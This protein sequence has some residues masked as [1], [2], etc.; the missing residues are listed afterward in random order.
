MIR[1]KGELKK[2][3]KHST[4]KRTWTFLIIFL[5]VFVLIGYFLSS[6]NRKEYL[7]YISESPS[8]T[9]VKAFYTYLKQEKKNV[10]RWTYSPENLIKNHNGNQLLIMIE[11]FFTPDSEEMAMYQSFIEKGNTI[12]L[13]SNN[14]HGMFD[15][16][17]DPMYG[18]V[19]DEEGQEIS[20]KNRHV[21]N[22]FTSPTARLQTDENDEILLYDALG[23]IA[24][25]R[26]FGEGQLIVAN[27]PHWLTNNHILDYDHIPLIASLMNE[28]NSDTIYI[29][30][31]LHGTQNAAT[32][33]KTYPLWFLLLFIQ[34]SICLILWLWFKGKRFGPIF[35]P[36][37]ETVRFSDEGISALASWYLKGKLY[38]ESLVIQADY[39]KQLLQERWGIPSS[40]EWSEMAED[41][42]RRNS[43]M[44][45]TKTQS[46]LVELTNLLRKK[47]VSKQ[48]FLLWSK[49]L[50]RLRKEVEQG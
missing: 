46:F 2:L 19:I 30:E 38:H 31:Y 1:K 3:Q 32:V 16:K 49:K 29:D 33:F 41:F 35:I 6:S 5:L 9:G 24:F 28:T 8:P 17:T 13:F 47:N 48:E 4:N 45:E 42:N 12:L 23:T 21:F 36:R 43:G 15:L 40:K 37:E 14:P 20:H 50:D 27:S 22:A 18:S 10:K 7:D 11:P 26:F 44:S 34:G 39:V 25:K